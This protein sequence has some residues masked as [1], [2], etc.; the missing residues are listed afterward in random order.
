MQTIFIIAS[1]SIQKR[2]LMKNIREIHWEE[3][4]A[5]KE[6]HFDDYV[7]LRARQKSEIKIF[8]EEQSK[9]RLEK[10]LEKK[11]LQKKKEERKVQREISLEK[12][13]AFKIELRKLQQKKKIL[14]RE[15]YLQ[16]SKLFAHERDL[17]KQI[18]GEFDR[19]KRINANEIRAI[20]KKFQPPRAE[21]FPV[22]PAKIRVHKPHSRDKKWTQFEVEELFRKC[23]EAGHVLPPQD[24]SAFY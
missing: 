15:C 5:L 20:K 18:R 10:R 16:T 9:R 24:I 7:E 3:R 12:N 22:A 8:K 13:R 2:V 17:K 6:K 1:L 11:A 19:L 21:T 4:K 14:N 23:V